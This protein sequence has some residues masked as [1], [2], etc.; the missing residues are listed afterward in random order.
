MG[1]GALMTKGDRKSGK[2]SRYSWARLCCAPKAKLSWTPEELCEPSFSQ[3]HAL[4]WSSFEDKS[5]AKALASQLLGGKPSTYMVTA[6]YAVLL[7]MV[8][9]LNS[10]RAREWV[11]HQVQVPGMPTPPMTPLL[12]QQI[13]VEVRDSQGL[14][15]GT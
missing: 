9:A 14:L 5:P 3:R 15:K 8:T 12:L 7:P 10:G 6:H 11:G 2:E 4:L 13:R 1:R